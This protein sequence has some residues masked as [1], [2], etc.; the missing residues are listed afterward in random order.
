MRQVQPRM[1]V[2]QGM[3]RRA[4]CGWVGGDDDAEEAEGDVKE[5]VAEADALALLCFEFV[6]FKEPDFED[7]I[8]G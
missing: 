2:N 1:R 3:V 7:R 4:V 5:V 6:V 8:F